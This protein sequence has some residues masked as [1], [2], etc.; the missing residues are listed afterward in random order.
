M[1]KQELL[2]FAR[3]WIINH[4]SEKYSSDFYAYVCKEVDTDAHYVEVTDWS[5]L[6]GRFL[7]TRGK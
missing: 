4:I 3:A 5:T 2:G 1:D 7:D 6:W